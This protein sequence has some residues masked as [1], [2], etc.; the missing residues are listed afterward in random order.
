[1]GQRILRA[2]L[3]LVTV[4]YVVGTTIDLAS[5]RHWWQKMTYWDQNTRA[6]RPLMFAAT[7]VL[8]IVPLG[9]L[10]AASRGF[11][12][13]G[14]SVFLGT[15]LLRVLVAAVILGAAL[16]DYAS[17]QS[18]WLIPIKDILSIFW[19]V[20]AFV[21]RTVIWRGAELKLTRDGR[22]AP[23]KAAGQA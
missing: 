5:P 22:F 11:D 1:M 14:V 6:A 17:L 13:V 16:G 3:K 18:L 23:A 21:K 2:G 19:F 8:R 9:L 20:R 7:L 15:I 10:F 4:P 12:L